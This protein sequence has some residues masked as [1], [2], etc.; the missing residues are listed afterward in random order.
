MNRPDDLLAAVSAAVIDSEGQ[1]RLLLR[2]IVMVAR[3]IFAAGASSIFLLDEDADQLVFEAV[4]REGEEE[5]VGR[6]FSA[7]EGIAGWVLAAGE[8]MVIGD[9][10][11]NSTFARGQAE[12]TGYV[13]T[14]LMAVP[15]L[16]EERPIGVLEVLD[17]SPDLV[18][19]LSALDL[20][21]LFAEQAALALAIVRRTRAVRAMLHESGGEFVELI[22]VARALD[23]LNTP[24]RAAGLQLL[25]SVRDLLTA[26]R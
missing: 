26:A 22:S 12:S 23:S 3:S 16:E 6:R 24:Q 4:S 18:N 5:L 19:S 13:P 21:A 7:T 8:P 14:S 1:H 20:L 10:S 9:L 15:L 11:S 25:G 17:F 2:S